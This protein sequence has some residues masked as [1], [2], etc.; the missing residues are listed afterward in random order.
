[1]K[2]QESMNNIKDNM[3]SKTQ[4]KTDSNAT[5][6]RLQGKKTKRLRKRNREFMRVT[7]IFISMF[8]ILCT[9]L[10]YFNVFKA[11]EINT[12]TYNTKRCV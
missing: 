8:L 11:E 4:K 2:E 12:N 5:D 3:D 1:M 7:W 10:V 6:T 9:Y